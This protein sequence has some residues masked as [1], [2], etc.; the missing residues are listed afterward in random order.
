VHGRR[1]G[2]WCRED[3]LFGRIAVGSESFNRRI[4]IVVPCHNRAAYLQVL[5]QSLTWSAVD[6]AD[7]EVIV[8]NDGGVDHVALVADMWRQR[9]LDVRVH[10]LRERG[11]PRNN[12]IARNTGL[13]LAR[14]PLV[15]QTDPD[16]VFVSD[17]LA[18]M[19]EA[20]APG[21]FC[22]CSAYYPLTR[23]ATLD[24]AFRPQG[25]DVSA[26]AYLERA[27]GRPNQVLSPD[28]VGG[29]HGAFLC[30]TDDLRR[31]GGYDESFRQWGWEDRELLTTLQRD[32]GLVRRHVA[33][34]PVVHLW[35]P[36][37]RG[38]TSREELAARGE[39]SCVAWDIQMQRASA[40][41][42]R[43]TRVRPLT[44]AT[45]TAETFTRDAYAGWLMDTT[46]D[47][48]QET[49]SLVY[50]AFFD[51]H[52]FEASQLHS[53][54]FVSLARDL[55]H[56]TLRRPWKDTERS[57]HWTRYAGTPSS[58]ATLLVPELDAYDHVDAVL[59]E[60]AACE[61]SLGEAARR[62]DILDTLAG[63]RGGRAMAAAARVRSALRDGDLARAGREV[64]CLRAGTWTAG[65]AALAIEVALLAGRPVEAAR[66]VTEMVADAEAHD[67]S[68]GDYFEQLRLA[69]YLG[70][71]D[72][73]LDAAHA[74]LDRLI[75]ALE[76]ERSEL[77]YSAAM[78][79]LKAGL[80]IAA[81]L[82][83]ERFL[84]SNSPAE[85]RLYEEGRAHLASARARVTRHAGP[86]LIGGMHDRV[87]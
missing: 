45:A 44:G 13:A 57:A 30:A 15:L 7:F 31:V 55:L 77:V 46:R 48:R 42:P 37:L 70:E 64:P 86:N 36:M 76:C 33:D 73:L 35:H 32:A 28:G 29:L 4:S 49:R 60:L 79:S 68:R 58:V 17:V 72:H 5:L 50:Q 27:A 40:E 67:D 26:T 38:E 20:I 47:E 69:A 2:N 87:K 22:S 75:A 1:T 16:I 54:G 43:S 52:R 18:R 34:T 59:D 78:R 80:D 21:T 41:Y 12:A 25:P 11:L 83:L 51:A 8:V 14:Y 85:A 10:Q 56:Y 61:D 81:C 65:G 66:I 63:R 24:L 19:R 62:D 39:L 53:L 3:D 6:V 82:L 71:V 84:C 74:P 23:E 9:G